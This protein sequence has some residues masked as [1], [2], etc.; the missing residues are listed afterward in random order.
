MNTSKKFS[1]AVSLFALI[2]LPAAAFA[3]TAAATGLV[4]CGNPGQPACDFNALTGLIN[5]I[6]NWFLGISVSIAA[7]TFAYAGAE[8]LFNQDKPAKLEEAKGIFGKTIIGL[9]VILCAW[10]I[11]HTII[12][13]LVGSNDPN[14]ALRFL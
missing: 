5:N 12:L 2:L 4:T 3:A 6:I 7:I 10:L 13:A 8:I 9:L 1:L 11:I 14:K